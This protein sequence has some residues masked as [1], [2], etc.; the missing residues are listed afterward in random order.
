MVLEVENLRTMAKF[1]T[2]SKER[3]I[4]EDVLESGFIHLPALA[5]EIFP[6]VKGGERASK[7]RFNMQKSLGKIQDEDITKIIEI[8]KKNGILLVIK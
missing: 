3:E 6:C 4:V 8:L 1:I 7:K 2:L 5:L